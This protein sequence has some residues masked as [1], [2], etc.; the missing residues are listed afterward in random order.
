MKVIK[1]ITQSCL[2]LLNSSLLLFLLCVSL[3]TSVTIFSVSLLTSL[4]LTVCGLPIFF[5]HPAISHVFRVPGFSG[6][7]SRIWVQVLEVAFTMWLK[8]KS[9][10]SQILFIGHLVKFIW[11]IV[12]APQVW[13]GMFVLVL[14]LTYH[15][16]LRS[17][18]QCPESWVVGPMQKKC[19]RSLVPPLGSRVSNPWSQPQDDS[20]VLGLTRSPRSHFS[21]MPS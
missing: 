13:Q 21:D 10:I 6:S 5:L 3:K 8:I 15:K 18:F 11:I 12:L 16:C 2:S 20:R 17:L 19:L 4:F 7:G 1:F 9:I 14:G